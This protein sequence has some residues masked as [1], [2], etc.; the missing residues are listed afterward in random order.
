MKRPVKGL[1]TSYDSYFVGYDHCVD[2]YD[3]YL[4]EVASVEN[5]KN[6]LCR[7]DNP[8]LDCERR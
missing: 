5:L 1:Y 7:S 8:R 3:A 4:S 2:D 6:V